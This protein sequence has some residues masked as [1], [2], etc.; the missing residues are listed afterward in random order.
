MATIGVFSIASV[1]CVLV[2]YILSKAF[3]IVSWKM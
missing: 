1:K 2:I 3:E